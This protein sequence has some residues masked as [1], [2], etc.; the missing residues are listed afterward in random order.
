MTARHHP[1]LR[2]TRRVAASAILGASLPLLSGA[3]LP[4]P[5]SVTVDI[6]GLRSSRGLIQACLTADPQS[7]PDCQRDPAARHVTVAAVDGPSVV[8]HH[9]LPGRYA[10]A[11]FHDENANGRLDKLLMVPREG[12]GFSR[13]APVRFGPPHFAAAEFPLNEAAMVTPIKVRYLL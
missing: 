2:K 7:F 5:S 9:V 12:F 13:D 8:F 10:I 11:L 3:A 6:E 1:A 4:T